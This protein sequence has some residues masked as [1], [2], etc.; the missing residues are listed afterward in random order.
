VTG[1]VPP[2]RRKRLPCS[3]IPRTGCASQLFR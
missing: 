3:P 2:Y 1:Y